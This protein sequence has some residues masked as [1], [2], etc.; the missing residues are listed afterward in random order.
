[1]TLHSSLLFKAFNDYV[2]SSLL[3]YFQI[4][5]M[6]FLN[7]PTFL[8]IH[9]YVKIPKV[10]Y[11]I[12]FHLKLKFCFF[13]LWCEIKIC[14][15]PVPLCFSLLMNLLLFVFPTKYKYVSRNRTMQLFFLRVAL[16]SVL[17]LFICLLKEFFYKCFL[18]LI[19][20]INFHLEI[21]SIC[22]G[23]ASC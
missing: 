9:K 14:I 22:N 21:V 18:N 19:I 16:R 5:F 10:P 4:Q 2:I 1:M 12:L 20:L 17:N 3:S 8:K 23:A 15:C 6:L 11:K 13:L 7:L